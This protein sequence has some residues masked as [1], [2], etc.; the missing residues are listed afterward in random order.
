MRLGDQS[1]YVRLDRPSPSRLG[2][3]DHATDTC[4]FGVCLRRNAEGRSPE[5]WIVVLNR[6]EAPSVPAESSTDRSPIREAIECRSAARSHHARQTSSESARKAGEIAHSNVPRWRQVSGPIAGGVRQQSVPRL[7][8]RQ[9]H[10]PERRRSVVRPS[11]TR[12][13]SK[14]GFADA[15]DCRLTTGRSSLSAAPVDHRAWINPRDE[16]H[17]PHDPAHVSFACGPHRECNCKR[18]RSH[19]SFRL[20]CDV[21]HSRVHGRSAV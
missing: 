6:L 17:S 2:Q 15:V 20:D 19:P 13:G 14:P 8:R 11:A 5:N 16:V 9:S 21:G 4:Q 10:R 7:T 3:D 1:A 12:L 18:S